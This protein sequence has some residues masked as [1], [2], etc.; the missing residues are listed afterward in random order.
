M[1][2]GIVSRAMRLNGAVV[3]SEALLAAGLAAFGVMS[4]AYALRL[5]LYR[6]EFT[7]DARDP[8]RAFGFF[9]FGAAAGVLAAPLAAAGNAAA[10][11][12]RYEPALWA[13]VFPVGM[14][15]V[16]SR[17]LGDVLHVSWLV[18]LG[19][20]EAWVALAAW[21]AVAAAMAAAAMG[22]PRA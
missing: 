11:D 12:V 19:R 4:G 15:G 10:A 13:A 22:S 17:E 14:Y 6:R 18:T 21:T 9:T 20:Y 1:G 2:T 5:A 7:A 3:L 16:A 8:R